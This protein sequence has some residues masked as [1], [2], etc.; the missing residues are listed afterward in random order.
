MFAASLFSN[1][2]SLPEFTGVFKREIAAGL[3]SVHM[4]YLGN[5]ACKLITMGL[6]PCILISIFFYPLRL[7]DSSD[8]NFLEFLK[9][10]MAQSFNGLSLGH[11]WGT[12]FENEMSAIISGFAVM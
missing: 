8:E 12:V 5:W 6:Y 10:G 4:Y 1:I 9:V 7:V 3:Y 2:V 11:M